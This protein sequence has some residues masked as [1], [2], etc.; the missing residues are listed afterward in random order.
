MAVCENSGN[1]AYT[2][3]DSQTGLPIDYILLDSLKTPINSSKIQSGCE[4]KLIMFGKMCDSIGYVCADNT[5]SVY[6]I[7][8]Q[9]VVF[10][11]IFP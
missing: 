6:N 2:G 5:V 11:Q 4:V 7:I 3:V 1:Y 8:T 9:T 10:T